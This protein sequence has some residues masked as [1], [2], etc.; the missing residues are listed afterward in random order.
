MRKF[1][2]I[3][4]SAAIIT[5]S[6][7]ATIG[8]TQVVH[9]GSGYNQQ[10]WGDEGATVSTSSHQSSNMAGFVQALINSLGDSCTVTND[11]IFGATTAYT[12]AVLEN[13]MLNNYNS[14]GIMSPYWMIALYNATVPNYPDKALGDMLFTDGY[15][16]HYWQY[17]SGGGA[18]AKLGWNPFAAQWLFAQDPNGSAMTQATPPK[19][20]SGVC[21][22]HP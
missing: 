16:T 12:A 8:P 20:I 1:Y 9:A 15:G 14:G 7:I 5:L 6:T 4:G 21:F 10:R 3:F 18:P 19:T 13:T 11:G 2:S 17:Y 22:N